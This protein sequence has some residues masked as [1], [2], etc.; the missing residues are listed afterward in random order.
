MNER[1][2]K[3]YALYVTLMSLIIFPA[4]NLTG[5]SDLYIGWLGWV[6]LSYFILGY[7]IFS[8][9][10]LR[11]FCKLIDKFKFKKKKEAKKK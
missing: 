3:G 1:L 9:E 10:I 8:I 11:R 2:F 6:F 5:L 7:Y 4:S